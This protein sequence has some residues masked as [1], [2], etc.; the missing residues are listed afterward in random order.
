MLKSK[1]FKLLFGFLIVLGLGHTPVLA[2]D[3]LD[4]AQQAGYQLTETDLPE[5]GIVIEATNGQIIWEKKA[6]QMI[7]ASDLSN[8]MTIYLTLEAI[9]DGTLKMDT[10]ITATANHEAISAL[11]MKNTAI[12][13]GVEYTVKELLQLALVPSSNVASVMLSNLQ[14]EQDATFVTK[15]NDKAKELGMTQTTFNTASGTPAIQFEGY[16]QPDGFDLYAG[17]Q[18]T[19]KDLATLAYHLLQKFPDILD[20]AKA[21]TFTILP[22]SLYE[23][24]IKND[25]ESLP[26]GTYS[27]KGV[28]G[29]K[30]GTSESGYQSIVT[31][32][33]DGLRVITVLTGVGDAWNPETKPAIFQL[34]NT[35]VQDVF[36]HYEYTEIL[37]AGEQ[38]INDKTLQ[39]EKDFYAVTKKDT[40]AS[41]VATDGT[42]EWMNHLPLVA[43]TV[44]PVTMSYKPLEETSLNTHPFLVSLIN[45]VEITKLTILSVGLVFLGIIFIVMSLFIPQISKE[46]AKTEQPTRRREQ[47]AKRGFPFK[48]V[49]RWLGIL[50]LISGVVILIIQYLV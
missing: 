26:K 34:S 6:E 8:L 10:K 22:N 43:D 12:S 37:A 35:L 20:L 2:D 13:S 30:I 15:M 3:L 28:D 42:I 18:T 40:D 32:R 45:A 11:E 5:T 41:F 29:L 25:N 4:K 47:R 23:E 49:I 36:K 7:D 48:R 1:L 21:E 50:S 46:E 31:A 33:Q 9:E 16:Y 27:L 17:N 39:V 14:D 44:A 38:T 24:T 19:A